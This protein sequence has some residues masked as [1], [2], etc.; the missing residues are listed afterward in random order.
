MQKEIHDFALYLGCRR[1]RLVHTPSR[2]PKGQRSDACYRK[3]RL[4]RRPIS[5]SAAGSACPGDTHC[6]LI[7]DQLRIEQTGTQFAPTCLMST[8]RLGARHTAAHHLG[9]TEF[10]VGLLLELSLVFGATALTMT[11][12]LAASFGVEERKC[13]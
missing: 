3:T 8:A 12:L 6:R 5:P 9:L 7:C 4:R 2:H 10:D 13:I 11:V 1:V